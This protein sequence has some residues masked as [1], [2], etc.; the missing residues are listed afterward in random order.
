MVALIEGTKAP[1]FELNSLDGSRYSL[2]EA[3]N[4]NPYV[5]LAFYKAECPVCQMTLPYLERLH[6]FNPDVPIWAMSQD[7]ADETAEF[8]SE[9]ELSMPVLLDVDLSNTVAYGLTNVPSLFLIS[10]DGTIEQ[11]IV[12]FAKQDLEDLHKRIARENSRK[13]PLFTDRDDVPAFRPG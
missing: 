12:G 13:E 11:T 9:Y 7:D 10:K 2:K 3:L 4:K 1:V 8:V 6:K 5:V